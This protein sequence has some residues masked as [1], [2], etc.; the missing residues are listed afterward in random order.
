MTHADIIA[1]ERA[2][3]HYYLNGGAGRNGYVE[4]H[5]FQ[6]GRGLGSMITGIIPSLKRFGSYAL[7]KA[8]NYAVGTARDVI[9]GK[10]LGE[11]LRDNAS[12]LAENVSFEAAEHFKRKKKPQ[13]K[14]QSRKKRRKMPPRTPRKKWGN[15]LT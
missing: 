6:K 11:S 10:N 8:A 5:I 12:A 14:S 2:V 13:K 9:N 15:L 4:N 7:K 3:A 1:G